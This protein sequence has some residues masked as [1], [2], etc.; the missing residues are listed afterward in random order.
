MTRFASGTRTDIKQLLHKPEGLQNLLQDISAKG[1]LIENTQSLDY[2]VDQEIADF[3]ERTTATRSDCD[4][5]AREHLGGEFV[6]VAVQGVC[7]YTVYAGPKDEFVAQFRLKFSCIDMETVNLARTIYGGFAPKA[8]FKGQT[9]EDVLG[10]EALYIYVMDRI[11]G[12]SYSNIILA[13]NNQ[14][15][16][17]S[18]DFP[19]WRKNLVLDV[20][21]FF[22]LSWKSPQIVDQ[23]YC[24]ITTHFSANQFRPLIQN[25]IS[26][27]P[28][29]FSLPM[30][31]LHRDFGVCNMMVNEITC[32]LVGVVDW[33]EAEVASFGLNLHSH[34]RLISKVHLKGGWVRYD[35][36]VTLEDIFWST[37]TNEAGGLSDETVK[38]IEAARIV[39]LLLSRGFTS[40]LSKTTEVVPIRDDKSRAYNMRDLDGL[41]INPATRFI[42]LA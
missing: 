8:V 31:L 33:A 18:V 9:G 27:L 28:A 35:D 32:N 26:S 16:E 17:T 24:D 5:F 20:T 37:F 4:A 41:L 38:T 39:G 2:S 30:V 23:S 12:I 42:D 40:R 36:N 6:P 7:G 11:Q 3:F 29:I 1:W 15:L 10:K 14:F 22:A 19:S 21:K 13:H 34:Q 25:S